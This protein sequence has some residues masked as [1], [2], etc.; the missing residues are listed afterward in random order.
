ML[1]KPITAF[2][3]IPPWQ[4]IVARLKV[5]WH[6]ANLAQPKQAAYNVA[7]L[8]ARRMH[9]VTQTHTNKQTK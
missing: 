2:F 6:K 9:I 4:Q 1:T 8:L 3:N 7:H 5:L